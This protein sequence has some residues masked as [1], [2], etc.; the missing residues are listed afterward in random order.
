[1]SYVFATRLT[2][3]VSLLPWSE[4]GFSPESAGHSIDLDHVGS[5]RH[6]RFIGTSHITGSDV[7]WK[8]GR[9]V[10]MHLPL[11]LEVAGSIPT[12]GEKYFGVRTRFT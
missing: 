6:V 8:R 5:K 2:R 4:A 10:D 7:K 1:M 3:L 11:V 9:S 12:R